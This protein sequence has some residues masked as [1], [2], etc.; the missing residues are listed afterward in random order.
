MTG[1]YG[2]ELVCLGWLLT[3]MGMARLCE[4][5]VGLC[6]VGSVTGHCSCMDWLG[7]SATLTWRC[8]GSQ[9]PSIV[10]IRMVMTE[11]PTPAYLF[12]IISGDDWCNFE[13]PESLFNGSV[14]VLCK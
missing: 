9:A 14:D 13:L 11:Y 10:F 4:S 3:V 2:Q 7:V 8:G 6:Y 5:R 1:D 12:H